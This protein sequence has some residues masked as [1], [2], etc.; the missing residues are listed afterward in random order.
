MSR[1]TI[2]RPESAN[3]NT[4]EDVKT[5]RSNS[6]RPVFDYINDESSWFNKLIYSVKV[7]THYKPSSKIEP[8]LPNDKKHINNCMS[9][10][11]KYLNCRDEKPEYKCEE[12]REF[13]LKIK[14]I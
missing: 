9:I 3:N 7:N 5:I 13:L 14:C 4:N 8:I 2:N 1:P 6:L 12:I 11:T 10:M